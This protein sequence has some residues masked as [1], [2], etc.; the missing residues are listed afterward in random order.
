VLVLESSSGG[1][2]A[3]EAVREELAIHGYD[4]RL[5]DDLPTVEGSTP[6]ED[7]ATYMMLSKFSILVDEEATR[8][9]SEYE[10]AKAHDNVLARL[11]P[12]DREG[13]TTHVIG[14][15]GDDDAEH[16]REF[17]YDD[18]PTEVLDEAI[19]WAESVIERRRGTELV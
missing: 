8:R 2:D 13:R 6:E 4:A 19:S 11:V 10:T 9:L 17:V 12:A 16:I 7:I 15:H 14:G 18:S 1:T 3:P 5:A